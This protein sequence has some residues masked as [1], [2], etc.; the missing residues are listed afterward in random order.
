MADDLKYLR[1]LLTSD[2][3]VISE[4]YKDTLPKVKKFVVQNKGSV[5][6]A[7]DVFQKALVQ[8]AVRYKK[9]PFSINSSF[10]AF[11][12]YRL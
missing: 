2:S 8:I 11:F 3:A 4:L 10:K 7:E 12:I 9:N 5:E 1:A 6:D